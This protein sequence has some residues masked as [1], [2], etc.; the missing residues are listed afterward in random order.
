MLCERGC[1]KRTAVGRVFMDMLCAEGSG[2]ASGQP[3][4][5]QR[6]TPRGAPT[7]HHQRRTEIRHLGVGERE[8]ARFIF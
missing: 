2:A 8:D 4:F 7:F 6:L 1:K 5:W 3:A